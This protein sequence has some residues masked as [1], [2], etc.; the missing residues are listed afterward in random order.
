MIRSSSTI[1]IFALLLCLGCNDSDFAGVAKQTTKNDDKS[2]K[3]KNKEGD[4]DK[5][6]DE[7]LDDDSNPGD[8]DNDNDDSEESIQ[9]RIDDLL[10][11][12]G[13]IAT[14]DGGTTLQI[15]R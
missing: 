1:V 8:D 9:S 2:D 3:D 10:S 4:K 12:N 13:K 5:D 14:E 15:Y 6:K 11:S 7:D